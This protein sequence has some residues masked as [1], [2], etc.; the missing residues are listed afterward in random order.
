MSLKFN[1]LS[2]NVIRRILLT[3][4]LLVCAVGSTFAQQNQRQEQKLPREQINVFWIMNF[5]KY[6]QW[7]N[8]TTDEFTI[9]VYGNFTPE[10]HRLKSMQTS[11]TTINGKKFKTLKFPSVS[12]I[13]YTNILFVH[14]NDSNYL[15]DINDKI[16][17]QPTLLIVDSCVVDNPDLFMVN[18]VRKSRSNQFQVNLNKASSVGLQISERLVVEGGSRVEVEHLNRD[19][20]NRLLQ[21]EKELQDK[22]WELDQKKEEIFQMSM[23]NDFQEEENSRKQQQIEEVKHEIAVQEHIADSLM[24]AAQRLQRKLVNDNA[25]LQHQQDEQAQKE[26]LHKQSLIELSDVNDKV[27]QRESSIEDQRKILEMKKAKSSENQRQINLITIGIAIFLVLALIVFINNTINRKRNRELVAVNDRIDSQKEHIRSQSEQLKLINKELEKLSIVASQTDNG[28]VIMDNVGNVEWVNHGFENLTKMTLNDLNRNNTKTFTSLY[29]SNHEIESIKDKCI[30]QCEPV[31][32]ECPF[33][34]A[35]GKNIWIQSTLTP[36]L[37]EN[38]EITRLVTIDTDISKIKEQ[39][40]SIIKQGETLSLQRDELAQQKEFISEQL[41]S[42]NTSIKYAK[43]IQDTVMP[44][45]V[46]L[47]KYFKYF[48]IFI[49]LQTISGDF[50]W[51]TRVP[52]KENLTFTAAVDCTGHGVPGAFMSMIGTRLLTEI[53]VEHNVHDPKDILTNLNTN[54]VKALKQDSGDEV[55]EI[56]NDSMEICLC[57]FDRLSETDYEM[58]FSGARR[59]LYVFRDDTKE[60]IILKG[61]KKTIGGMKSKRNTGTDFTDQTLMLHTGDIVYHTTDGFVDQ[62]DEHLKK[63]GSDRFVNLLKAHA[64][65]DLAIQKELILSEYERQVQNSSQTD[66]ITVFAVKLI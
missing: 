40:Q 13:E 42:I 43:T 21:K 12:K 54:L 48:G 38:N 29:A 2:L 1:I 20:E 56:N 10:Y 47:S 39:E 25:A 30:N 63:Y 49:P 7:P 55:S 26:A 22:E 34:T 11:G 37:N 18:L 52:G 58:T 5:A 8:D 9:G 36:I 64:H 14:K 4:V 59:P 41:D 31:T 65:R 44:L 35:D 45:E 24:E 19:M 15:P 66:D 3:A 6:V 16:K 51:F 61:D 32:F 46:N 60:F 62:Y 50:Y 33:V 28:V 57:K 53:I 23:N 17:G 27:H